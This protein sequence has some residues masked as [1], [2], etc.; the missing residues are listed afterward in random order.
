MLHLIIK[1]SLSGIATGLIVSVALAGTSSAHPNEMIF[2]IIGDSRY[3][4]DFTAPRSNGQHNATDIIASKGQK[5]ISAVDGT[6]TFVPVPEPSYGYMVRVRDADGFQYDYIHINNDT[7][8][9]DDGAGGPMNAYAPDM[10]QNYPIKKGQLIGYVG[11]SGN[12]EFTV[13]HLHFEVTNPD[14]SKF[15]AYDLLTRARKYTTPD[16]YPALP[17]ESLPFGEYASNKVSIA[18]GDFD[19]DGITE[20]AVGAGAGGGPQVRFYNLDGSIK[21]WGFF[22][23]DSRYTGGVTVSAGDVDGD[24]KDELITGTNPGSTTHVRVFRMSGEIIGGFFAYDGFYTGVNTA[25]ADMD[26]DGRAEIIT[27]TG[28]GSTTHIKT[29]KLDGTYVNGFF[30][31]D[32]YYVGADVAAG[33]VDGDGDNEIVTAPT[34]G[35]GPHVKVFAANGE[36]EN[37]FFAYSG[38]YGG[39]HVAVGNV[40]TSSAKAEIL[41]S[42]YSGGGPDFRMFNET[43]Q[44][45]SSRTNYESWWSGG[46]DITPITNGAKIGT[47][48]TRRSSVRSLS[49]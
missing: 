29:F 49:F 26:N 10:K 13:S 46:Y 23:Y 14:G 9:T 15:N 27:G 16:V 43:G 7:P 25:V 47:G 12:S 32:G 11:D 5:I 2:P 4:N 48:E 22:A 28:P 3:S 37:D 6:I 21:N 30:A 38:F 20:Y 31:Y 45:I 17:G 44:L 36:L 8:G 1:S 34:K 33:D 42:P 35:G 41:T 18:S 40:K 24:G 19:D 39:V